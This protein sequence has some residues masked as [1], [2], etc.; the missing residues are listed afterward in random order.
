MF[1]VIVV[2]VVVL[3]AS[4]AHTQRQAAVAQVQHVQGIEAALRAAGKSI[5]MTD[6]DRRVVWVNGAFTTLTGYSLDEVLG[7]NL[8]KV[9]QFEKTDPA[10][11]AEMR[12]ALHAG[13]GFDGTVLNRA[14]DGREYWVQAGIQPLR[15]PSGKLT[16]FIAIQSDLTEQ[17][18]QQRLLTL[19]NERFEAAV[20]GTSDGLWAWHAGE[21]H[22]WHSPRV[23]QLLGVPAEAP[24]QPAQLERLF[25]TI[26]P[27]DVQAARS[28]FQSLTTSSAKVSVE[29][30]LKLYQ[31]G[32]RWF[33][34]RA[35]S[36]QGDARGGALRPAHGGRRRGRA[37]QPEGP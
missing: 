35:S 33:S 34:V 16:G 29:L 23:L 26:H 37:A 21:P 27:D 22:L 10:T 20:E 28:T 19:A 3:A 1:V 4:W 14:R 15:D 2:T 18:E 32:Y 36:R 25:E 6:L 12:A 24:P 13:L 7:K 11:I 8:G 9:L 31:G 30:R 5:V 17:R